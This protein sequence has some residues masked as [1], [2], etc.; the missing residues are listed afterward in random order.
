MAVSAADLPVGDELNAVACRHLQQGKKWQRIYT[1]LKSSMPAAEELRVPEP[2]R[3]LAAIT[4]LRLFVT[5]TFDALLQRALDEARYGGQPKTEVLAYSPQRGQD[6][7]AGLEGLERS[8][9]FH[10]F[11]RLSATPSYA[12]TQEDTLEFVHALEAG[13]HR[14]ELLLDELERNNLLLLGVSFRGWLARFFLRT[15]KRQPLR[16]VR[17]TTDVVADAWVRD[18]PG[19]AVFLRTF[20]SGT[21]VFE[22]GAVEFVSELHRRWRQRHPEDPEGVAVPPSPRSRPSIEP[23]SVFLSYA[24]EDRPAAETLAAALEAA[25]IDV[26]F[27]QQSLQAGDDFETQL[28]RAIRECSL[29]VA[30]ISQHALS[31]QR[32]FFRLEWS[33]ALEESLKAPGRFIL[34]VAL[35]DTS[36]AAAQLPEKFR[37]LHWQQAPGGVPGPDFVALLREAFRSYQRSLRRIS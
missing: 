30:M 35:D 31:E 1:A 18:D 22:G 28:R 11:G 5:T 4:P 33:L 3:Q 26:F 32:R 14:P 20:S 36:P 17:G 16:A 37:R 25:G 7:A 6:L 15:A 29:F 13:T 23:G 24:S 12:V 9:V 10:L 8:T 19:L 27:D 2:L 21:E 34:P